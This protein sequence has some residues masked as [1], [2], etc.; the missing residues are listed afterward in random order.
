M[1]WLA[2][3]FALAR[4]VPP[5]VFDIG[6]FNFSMMNFTRL[7]QSQRYKIQKFHIKFS[8]TG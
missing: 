3:G 7:A 4:G 6:S 1:S 2:R 8:M 5:F